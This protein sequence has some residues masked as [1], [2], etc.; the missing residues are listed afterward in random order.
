MSPLGSSRYLVDT[1]W[2][3]DYLTGQ[4][5]A[6][7]LLTRLS[8]EGLAVSIVGDIEIREGIVGGRERAAAEQVFAGFLRLARVLGIS[9]E[10]ADLTAVLR[11]D[12][13]RERKPV[14]ERALDLFVAATALEHGLTLVTR[15]TRHYRDIPGLVLYREED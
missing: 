9:R 2:A 13:R 14:K 7:A 15:N 4:E 1:D 8:A 5:E 11:A 6:R 10:V 12:L 3:I